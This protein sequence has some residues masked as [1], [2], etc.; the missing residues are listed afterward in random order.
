MARLVGAL[1]LIGVLWR[2]RNGVRIGGPGTWWPQTGIARKVLRIGLP[3]ALEEVLIIS[4]FATLTP[5]VASLGTVGLAA[6]RVVINAPRS[7]FC[8]AS[9]S[10]WRRPRWWARRSARAVWAR[11]RRSP[12]SRCAGP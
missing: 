5:V 6:H 1:L 4:A 12:G 11:S 9:A 7:R 8:P 2:G 3:A 10:A